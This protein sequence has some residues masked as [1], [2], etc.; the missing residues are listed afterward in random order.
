MPSVAR[1]RASS[2]VRYLS[3]VALAAASL[4][5]PPAYAGDDDCRSMNFG[6]MGFPTTR[7]M[8]RSSTTDQGGIHQL[9]GDTRSHRKV[10]QPVQASK[11]SWR[12][13][14]SA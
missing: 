10:A 13:M 9:G 11:I 4:P 5:A 1:T 6:I 2:V 12:Q 3:V 7:R 8:G 14:H